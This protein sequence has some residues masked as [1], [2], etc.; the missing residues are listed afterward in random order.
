MGKLRRDVDISGSAVVLVD[1]RSFYIEQFQELVHHHGFTLRHAE[2]LDE[3]R[4]MLVGGRQTVDVIVIEA[5]REPTMH[6]MGKLTRD[7]REKRPAD[8]I[9]AVSSNSKIRR[10]LSGDGAT[11]VCEGAD[12]KDLLLGHLIR[13][14]QDRASGV[15]VQPGGEG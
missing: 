13:I 9:I 11:N 6:Q 10:K 14:C 4:S 5:N 7:I 1:P 8:I 12:L 15:S 2:N 3:A